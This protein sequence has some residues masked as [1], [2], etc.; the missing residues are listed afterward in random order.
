MSIAIGDAHGLRRKRMSHERQIVHEP[1][2]IAQVDAL[3]AFLV[4][5][6]AQLPIGSI[7]AAQ[8]PRH[9]WRGIAG[10][11]LEKSGNPEETAP[12]QSGKMVLLFCDGHFRLPLPLVDSLQ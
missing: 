8:I 4:P 6:Q 5:P 12:Q 3:F 11:S 10:A 7:G 9:C 1:P 2:L